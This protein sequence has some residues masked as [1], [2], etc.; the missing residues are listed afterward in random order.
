MTIAAL[1]LYAMLGTE[2]DGLEPVKLAVTTETLDETGLRETIKKMAAAEGWIAC[3][4]GPRLVLDGLI[5]DLADEIL[6][7]GE[8]ATGT[9]GER[10]IHF[11]SLGGD[12]FLVSNFEEYGM[13]NAT[14]LR[15]TVELM[16]ENPVDTLTYARYWKTDGNGMTRATS[17][18]LAGLTVKKRKNDT[19]EQQ[20]K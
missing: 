6:I 15:E 19:L 3:T 12:K 10:S 8:L 14:H 4:S 7:A 18:R 17:A 2:A 5:P 20:Q 13:A 16:G 9:E 1:E 11:R